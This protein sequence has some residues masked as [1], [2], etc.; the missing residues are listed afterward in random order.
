M[1]GSSKREYFKKLTDKK[2]GFL[3][4]PIRV[5]NVREPIEEN[6]LIIGFEQAVKM[7]SVIF[8]TGMSIQ[9]NGPCKVVL[10]EAV[11]LRPQ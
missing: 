10:N 4:V 8:K 1:S 9:A 2:T 7:K 3:L 11:A 5:K 6:N